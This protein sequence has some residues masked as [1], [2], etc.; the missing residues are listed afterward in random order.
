MTSRLTAAMTKSY[1]QKLLNMW[2]PPLVD[3]AGMAT[4]HFSFAHRYK[5]LSYLPSRQ[6]ILYKQAL[7]G[8]KRSQSCNAQTAACSAPVSVPELLE[9]SSLWRSGQVLVVMFMLPFLASR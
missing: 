8:L 2:W 9:S 6:K 7:Q 5:I 1:D 3:I 4:W